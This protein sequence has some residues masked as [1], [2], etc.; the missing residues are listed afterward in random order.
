MRRVILTHSDGD[1][2]GGLAGFPQ[3]LTIIAQVNARQEMVQANAAGSTKLPLPNETFAKE[4][5]LFVGDTPVQLLYFGPAH[6]SGD[7]VIYF[8]TE[9]AAVV[10]D[11]IFIGRDPLIHTN[12]HGTSFGLVSVLRS[13]VRLDANLFFSGHADGVDKNAVRAL[14]ADIAEKQAAIKTIVEHGGTLADAKKALNIADQPA[15]PGGRRWPSLVEVI[16]QELAAKPND[17]GFVSIFDGQTLKGWHI[18]AQSGHS[19]KSGNKSGG[20]WVV[21]NGV[22]VGSQDIPGNG[23]L[24]MTDKQYG[25]YEVALEM[26]N[27]FGPDSGLFLRSDEKGTAYQAMIDYYRGGNLM[28]LYGEAGLKANPSVRNFSFL[29]APRRSA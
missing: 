12:K 22:I 28:G 26:N 16:Y 23:G 5:T 27:D 15:A 29:D 18:D 9:K 8:P 24:L 13:I 25:D 17:V 1:H 4:L 7:I 2:V 10:G 19:K 14:A 11:L 3:P 6:T 21:E 20:R